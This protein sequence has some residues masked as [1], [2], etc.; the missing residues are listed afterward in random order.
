ME[1]FDGMNEENFVKKESF[2]ERDSDGIF[3]KI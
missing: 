3:E 1:D 2:V